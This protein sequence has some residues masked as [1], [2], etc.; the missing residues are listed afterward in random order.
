[1]TETVAVVPSG[2][3]TGFQIL[4]HVSHLISDDTICGTLWDMAGTRYNR[5]PEGCN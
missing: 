2:I 5:S 3:F 1:M 4:K